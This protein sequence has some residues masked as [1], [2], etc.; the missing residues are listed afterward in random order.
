MLLRSSVNALDEK[1]KVLQVCKMSAKKKEEMEADS[2]KQAKDVFKIPALHGSVGALFNLAT[3]MT[4][5]A[6]FW[7]YIQQMCEEQCN[8]KLAVLL[9][10]AKK[11]EN[12]EK[13][14]KVYRSL[15]IKKRMLKMYVSWVAMETVCD[16]YIKKIKVSREELYSYLCENPTIEESKARIQLLCREFKEQIEMENAKLAE[17]MKK[18]SK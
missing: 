15:A 8:G 12:C 4:R 3:I 10:V 7:N 13:R 14:L 1:E 9:D 5:T 18:R 16:D 11:Y 17:Q 6:I 2:G